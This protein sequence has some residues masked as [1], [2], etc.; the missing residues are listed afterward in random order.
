MTRAARYAELSSAV[1]CFKS[2]LLDP[3][4]IERLVETGSFS[5][6]VNLLT[7]GQV[8]SV[9][10]SDIAS[11][12]AQLVHKALTLADRLLSYAPPDSLQL[13]RLFAA[14]YE[15]QCAKEV[16]KSIVYQVD[17]QDALKHIIPAG[18]YTAERC[19]ELIE[20]R[21]TNRAIDVLEDEALRRFIS[22]NLMGERSGLMVASAL[23]QYYLSRL[24][25]RA[26]S[27]RDLI[28]LQV[29]RALIGQHIDHLNILLAIRAH[30]VGLDARS[31]SEILV[32]A[33]YRLGRAL[34][35]LPE[36]GSLPNI[37][38]VLDS[39]PYAHALKE[40]S[41]GSDYGGLAE[42]EL[43]LN[44]NLLSSCLAM[45]AGSPFHVGLAL[46][47]L[48][49]KNYELHDLFTIL[50]AKANSIPSDRILASLILRIPKWKA[51]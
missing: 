33:N 9:A 39:T 43:V 48:I 34:S 42:V 35:E 40:A 50:N 15:F 14:K 30:L 20:A 38:R 23:D 41:L 24:W 19:K 7:G 10:A 37:I 44:R 6:T 4:R 28:D 36:A 18:R 51:L 17:A 21:D 27:L 12:E 32:P 45:F 25:R 1:R 31:T 8:S 22:P 5:E 29:A 26:S 47:F 2:E 3:H 13:I 16:L 11:L 49:I 46:G